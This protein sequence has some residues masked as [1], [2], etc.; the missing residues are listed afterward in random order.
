MDND[1]KDHECGEY[2]DRITNNLPGARAATAEEVGGK[3]RWNE[4]YD[5]IVY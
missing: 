5:D 3:T 2:Q 4:S 1:T